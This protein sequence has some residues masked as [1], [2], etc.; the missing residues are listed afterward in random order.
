[1]TEETKRSPGRPQSL[2]RDQRYSLRRD[3]ESG[4]YTYSQLQEVYGVGRATIFRVVHDLHT[5]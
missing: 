5:S 1:M 2:T 4:D 3:H